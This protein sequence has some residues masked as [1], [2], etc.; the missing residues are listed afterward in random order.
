MEWVRGHKEIRVEAKWTLQHRLKVV[1]L[2]VVPGEGLL[3]EDL[4]AIDLESENA[5]LHRAPHCA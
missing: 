1:P 4:V 2:E 3:H 5:A